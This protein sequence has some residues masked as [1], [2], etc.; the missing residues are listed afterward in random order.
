MRNVKKKCFS[1]S[2]SSSVPACFLLSAS[3]M[4]FPLCSAVRKEG[5]KPL[6]TAYCRKRAFSSRQSADFQI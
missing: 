5:D 4:K 6:Y 3:C 1:G 2:V